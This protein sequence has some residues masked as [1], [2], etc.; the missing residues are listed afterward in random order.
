MKI[1]VFDPAMCCSTGVCGT[2]P[3]PALARFAADL[4]W[5]RTQGAE[6]DRFN[7]SQQPG[8]F[9]ESEPVRSRLA[10]AG[11]AALPMILVGGS[12]ISQGQYPNRAELAGWT[13]ISLDAQQSIFSD[14]VSELVAIGAA[15]AAGCQSCLKFHFGR[16]R[17]LG[18]SDEDMRRAVVVAEA[19]KETPA[20]AVSE[21]AARYLGIPAAESSC[22]GTASEPQL[23]QVALPSSNN[24][25]CC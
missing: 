13:G 19:V 5:L 25:K 2:S 4:N 21:L 24:S 20:R 16:A 6:V 1:E 9:A 12:V 18:V 23:I 15:V 7:L 11:D 22:C 14:A 17:E 8:A 3:D 10:E